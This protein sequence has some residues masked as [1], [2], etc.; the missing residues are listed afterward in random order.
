MKQNIM[1]MFDLYIEDAVQSVEH[2]ILC[3][4][5]LIFLFA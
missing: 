2:S 4:F 5:E 3:I 1:Q